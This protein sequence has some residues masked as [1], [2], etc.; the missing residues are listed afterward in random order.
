MFDLKKYVFQGLVFVFNTFLIPLPTC[1]LPWGT[2]I[3]RQK[4]VTILNLT[5]VLK[6]TKVAWGKARQG[7]KISTPVATGE[8]VV[9][10]L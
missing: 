3:R 10:H 5:S 7:V 1:N 2:A 8:H 4:G 6:R 9:G